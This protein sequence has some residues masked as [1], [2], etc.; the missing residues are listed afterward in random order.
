M[1]DQGDGASRKY[2]NAGA[3]PAARPCPCLSD[4]LRKSD[5]SGVRRS[6][7]GSQNSLLVLVLNFFLGGGASCNEQFTC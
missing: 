5:I 2:V 6:D 7:Q 4:S 1:P 3:L